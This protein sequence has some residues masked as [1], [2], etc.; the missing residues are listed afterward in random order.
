MD[1]GRLYSTLY[2]YLVP[3]WLLLNSFLMAASKIFKRLWGPGI[4]SKE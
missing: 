3:T 4:D 2:S 1:N